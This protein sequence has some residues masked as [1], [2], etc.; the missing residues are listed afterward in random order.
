MEMQKYIDILKTQVKPALGCTE[1]AAVALAAAQAAALLQGE[2]VRVQ[3]DVSP[4]IFKNGMR[5]GI[6]GTS[7]KGLEIA[8]ALGVLCGDAQGGLEVLRRVNTS[9]TQQAQQFVT[10]KRVLL[11][12]EDQK[13][14]FYIRA[15]VTGRN[16]DE[17][18]CVIEKS[19]TNVT[20]LWLNGKATLLQQA[21]QQEDN[22]SWLLAE[23]KD[24]SVADIRKF[25][26]T[27]EFEQI[28]FL[29]D[30]VRVN[31]DM[32]AYGFEHTLGMAVGQGLRALEQQGILQDD[33]ANHAKMVTAS[34]C[35]AR[36]A[37]VNKPVMSSAGSGNHG[38][39][40][41][42]PVAVVC[43][44]LGKDEQT[45]ARALAIS[46]LVTAYIKEYT[47]K[48]SPICGCAVA[49]GI[50]A[51]VAISWLYGGND[52][53]LAGAIRNMVGTVAGMLCDGAKGGCALKLAA[54][55]SEAVIQAS[56]AVHDIII[57]GTDGIVEADAE[58]TIQNLGQI[59]MDGM[60]DMDHEII[61]VMLK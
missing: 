59:C 21:E 8:A 55:A 18:C 19:H 38:L 42:L 45:L 4:N 48:L 31:M 7:S 43:E 58:G 24:L 37:G 10:E 2:P 33:I 14:N 13:G 5:V 3:V 27:V 34:A 35:D 61:N 28:A 20:G 40:A 39:T 46:H 52:Q 51:S 54:A 23:L 15:Q 9:Y 29:L 60:R 57:D 44:R 56:L 11:Q 22:T 25:A 50:G 26:E 47:G 12:V 30:G 17:S 49:A 6:P 41:I 32:A 53:Q 36:M 16:G 1:P